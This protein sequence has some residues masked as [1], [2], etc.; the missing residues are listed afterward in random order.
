M[1]TF[2]KKFDALK[3]CVVIPTYNNEKT[4]KR[5]IDSVAEYTSAIII[6]NDGSTDTTTK[7]LEPYRTQFTV[8]DFPVN[9]GKGAALRKGFQIAVANGFEYAIT[10]DSDGQHFADDLPIFLE[11]L[12]KEPNSLLI[13][14]RNMTHESVPKKSSFGNKF[15]NFWFWAETGISLTDTQSGYRLY[16]V[17][18]LKDTFYFTKRFE[19]EIEVIV[20]AA[21]KRIRVKNIP[22]KVL[23][24][25]ERVSHFRPG[26][27]FF[28]ISVLNT[29]LVIIALLYIKPRDLIYR[30]KKKGIKKFFT[31]EVLRS[32]DSPLVKTNSIALGVFIGLTPLWGLHSLL[33]IS[34]AVLFKLNKVIS[35]TFSNVSI[36]IFI[37]FIIWIS[38]KIGALVL[39]TDFSFDL[40]KHE[41][42]FD[43]VLSLKEYLVGSFIFAFLM[44]GLSWTSAFVYFK[45]KQK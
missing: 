27:D 25:E 30:L 31:E 13:G 5:V 3:C 23:Y 36:P 37:P 4:L 18:Q 11:E 42:N 1:S 39:G 32:Q 43:F 29:F 44:S 26:V 38:I 10:I 40:E 19:F 33:A 21:W 24:S 9:Q 41:S 6:V 14:S 17:G 20:R 2:P 28:R 12:E 16:P 34:L 22:I 15:S 45:S 7:I 35:F 8:E